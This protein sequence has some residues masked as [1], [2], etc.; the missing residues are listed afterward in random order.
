MIFFY[1]VR[2]N[3]RIVYSKSFKTSL[4]NVLL[5]FSLLRIESAV[6]D[7]AFN[8]RSA[9]KQI[10]WRCPQFYQSFPLFIESK[11]LLYIKAL[12][13]LVPLKEKMWT[14]CGHCASALNC[15]QIKVQLDKLASFVSVSYDIWLKYWSYWT[16]EILKQTVIV[17]TLFF[18]NSR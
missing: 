12:E 5:M 4:C 8:K 14:H 3:R 11:L 6:I 9:W 10:V 18:F 7:T 17:W 2:W 1:K 16:I 15:W 13:C